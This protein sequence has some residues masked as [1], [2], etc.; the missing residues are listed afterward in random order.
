MH[1]CQLV[2]AVLSCLVL[3]WLETQRWSLTTRGRISGF[4]LSPQKE[5][6]PF[7]M[8]QDPLMSA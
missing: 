3:I 2:L 8:W 1:L 5:D 4:A 6:E 7:R